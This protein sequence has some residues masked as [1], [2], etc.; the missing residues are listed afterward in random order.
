MNFDVTLKPPGI[1][2]GQEKTISFKR[3]SSVD[4]DCSLV[5]FSTITIQTTGAGKINACGFT[6][7][8]VAEMKKIILEKSESEV[9]QSKASELLSPT[10]IAH[11]LPY[12][13]P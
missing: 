6:K 2:S 5:D 3:I 9:G 12:L 10:L 4:V 13:F 7:S 8:E 1:F 11:E